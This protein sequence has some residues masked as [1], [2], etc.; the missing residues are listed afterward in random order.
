M[1]VVQ[2]MHLTN[3]PAV[4]FKIYG[5][6]LF[7]GTIYALD[8]SEAVH[9]WANYCVAITDFPLHWKDWRAEKILPS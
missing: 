8:A 7:L 6:G 2:P 1:V 4:F 9:Y 3:N 5:M